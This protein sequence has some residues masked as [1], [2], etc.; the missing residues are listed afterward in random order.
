MAEE[1]A[2]LLR[3]RFYDAGTKRETR[4]NME[5]GGLPRSILGLGPVGRRSITTDDAL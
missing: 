2:K 5:R 4:R 3:W 1:Q